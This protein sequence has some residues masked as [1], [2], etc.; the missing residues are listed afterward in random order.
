MREKAGKIKNSRSR[1]GGMGLKNKIIGMLIIF[2]VIPVLLVGGS[3]Y[4]KSKDIIREQ[5]ANTGEIVRS[6]AENYI[7]ND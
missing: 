2:I 6:Q 5:Q 3:A 7:G 4:I 1:L